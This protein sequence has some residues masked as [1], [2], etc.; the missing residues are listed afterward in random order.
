MIVTFDYLYTKKCRRCP[1][2]LILPPYCAVLTL[3]L[4]GIRA[5]SHMDYL[6]FMFPFVIMFYLHMHI[7]LP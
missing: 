3:R 7:S 1:S 2:F 4:S 5:S 6:N